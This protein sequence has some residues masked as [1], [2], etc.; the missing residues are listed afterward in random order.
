MTWQ[1]LSINFFRWKS[2]RRIRKTFNHLY[3]ELLVVLKSKSLFNFF[4]YLAA[5]LYEYILRIVLFVLLIAS[6]SKER[7]SHLIRNAEKVYKKGKIYFLGLMPLGMFSKSS[8][9]LF[10]LLNCEDMFFFSKWNILF[11]LKINCIPS[12]KHLNQYNNTEKM[13]KNKLICNSKMYT[14]T[15]IYCKYVHNKRGKFM[16][17]IVKRHISNINVIIYPTLYLYTAID[18]NSIKPR[19]L[20]IQYGIHVSLLDV[21]DSF[22]LKLHQPCKH[23]NVRNSFALICIRWMKRSY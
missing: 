10:F 17:E 20:T 8:K 6:S 15:P 19:P 2:S 22:D 16:L 1:K 21:W 5:L 9:H 23:L 7:L 11:I 14:R 13:C 12:L 3:L 18:F 4:S